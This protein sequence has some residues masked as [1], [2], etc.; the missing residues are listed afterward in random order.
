M[1]FESTTS[2]ASGVQ[3][4]IVE[5]SAQLRHAPVQALSQQTPST[6]MPDTHSPSAAHVTPRFFL[7]HCPFTQAWPLSQSPSVLHDCVQAAFVHRNGEQ[8]C[9]PWGRQLPRPSHVPGVFRRVPVHDG[10]MHT[11]SAA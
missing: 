11:V 5:A 3:W 4:P 8:F 2:A 6:H 10:A 1:P 9:T 7:P